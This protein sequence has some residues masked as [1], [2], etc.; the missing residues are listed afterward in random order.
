M[1]RLS[2]GER[3]RSIM[4]DCDCSFDP[5]DGERSDIYHASVRRARKPTVC[6]ECNAPIPPGAQY[7]M[8]DVLSDGSWG[9][10][11]TCMPCKRIREHYCPSCWVH[12]ELAEQI[13]YCLGFDYR[14]V[15]DEEED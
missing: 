12:E 15:E 2:C 13:S 5:G 7:E 9:H 10:W 14:V 1:W 8:A 11:A 3:I 4:T 6:C